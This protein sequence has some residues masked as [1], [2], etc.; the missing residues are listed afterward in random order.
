M[1]RISNTPIATAPHSQ[2]VTTDSKTIAPDPVFNYD[3]VFHLTPFLT[4][5]KLPMLSLVLLLFGMF[6]GVVQDVRPLRWRGRQREFRVDQQAS[7]RSTG[8]VTIPAAVTVVWATSPWA[9]VRRGVVPYARAN[10]QK[11]SDL[12]AETED[13]FALADRPWSSPMSEIPGPRLE[14]PCQKFSPRVSH[15]PL[16]LLERASPA[17]RTFSI[18]CEPVSY[19]F[20]AGAVVAGG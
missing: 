2:G 9:A 18:V 13:R 16:D 12:R 1:D 19:V 10:Q 6:E 3:P 7:I 17:V 15:S 4:A 20:P 8:C 11:R 5:S 14:S